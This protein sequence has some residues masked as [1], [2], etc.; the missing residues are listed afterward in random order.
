MAVPDSVAAV[1]NVYRRRR[2]VALGVVAILVLVLLVLVVRGCGGGSDPSS[3][4][5]ARATDAA[6]EQPLPQLPRGGRTIL[7]GHRVIAYYGN[8][9]DAELGI[10]GIGTPTRAGIRLAAVAKRYQTIGT[11]P[12]LPAMELIA[13]VADGVP[14]DSGAYRT[15]SDDATIRR[16]LR[17]ARRM[18]ALLILD[19]QPGRSDFL[20]ESVHLAK[21]LRQ[22]D[23]S[24][25]LDPEWR[26]DAPKV[27]G[28]VFGSVTAREVNAVSFWL[29]GIVA[30]HRLPQKLLLI[31]RFTPSMIV[32]QDQVK[33][34][35]GLAV[36]INVD[37]FGDQ[38]NKK[39]K[40]RQLAVPDGPFFNGFKLFHKEDT[41]LM[42]PRQVVRLR[43][44]PN[45]VVYE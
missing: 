8:P 25:A 39:V 18:K 21:W 30:K 10:L 9:K 16:Y 2:A 43:P 14:G 7:P 6:A 27:P 17:A 33:Q 32:D 3:G 45:V 35:A 26:V 22:P 41:D 13:T 42:T 11:V 1:Q 15:R 44:S 24:L 12:T 31:H 37:G 19:I 4:G 29:A 36:T 28:Q 23:V 34:R 38:P 40:Y 5:S 20:Q